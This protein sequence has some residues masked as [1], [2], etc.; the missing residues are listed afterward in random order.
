MSTSKQVTVKKEDIVSKPKLDLKYLRDRDAE[1]V[2]GIFHFYEVPGGLLEFVYKC[3]KGDEPEK[4]A[5][6]D[7]KVYSLPRG[8]ARHLNKSG[9]YPVHAYAQDESGRPVARVSQKV[10]RYGF[11]SLEFFD[12]DDMIA[13]GKPLITVESI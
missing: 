13:E 7:N 5:L 3:Y 12:S 1:V 8:V 6:E 10:A 4:Y 11:S 9:W 2:R